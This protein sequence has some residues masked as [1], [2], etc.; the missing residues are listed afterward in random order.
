MP[1]A[2]RFPNDPSCLLNVVLSSAETVNVGNHVNS[3]IQKSHERIRPTFPVHKLH[4]LWKTNRL[5]NA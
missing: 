1:A 3:L 5:T 4:K 2:S